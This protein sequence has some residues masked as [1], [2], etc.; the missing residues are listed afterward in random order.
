MQGITWGGGI[1]GGEHTHISQFRTSVLSDTSHY[2]VVIEALMAV[3]RWDSS[4]SSS[5]LFDDRLS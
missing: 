5:S 4:S 2:L 3:R 1:G